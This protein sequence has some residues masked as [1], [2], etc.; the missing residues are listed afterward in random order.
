VSRTVKQASIAESGQLTTRHQWLQAMVNA[1]SSTG[2]IPTAKA[3]GGTGSKTTNSVDKRS[4][5]KSVLLL[6]SGLVAGPAVDVLAGRS[7]VRLVIGNLSS[8]DLVEE[9]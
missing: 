6:G 9:S 3:G 8:S 4:A 5:P 2:T 7:D 1:L